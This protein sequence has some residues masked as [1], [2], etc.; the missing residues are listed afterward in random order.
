M[1]RIVFSYLL[2]LLSVACAAQTPI[3]IQPVKELKPT[4]NLGTCGYTPVPTEKPFYDKLSEK[5]RETGSFLAAYDIHQKNAEYVSWFGI[6]RGIQRMPNSDS[7]ELLL[8]QKYFDGMTDCHIMLVSKSGSGDFAVRLDAKN[9]P[10]PALALVR[11]YG[12]VTRRENATP[13]VQAEFVRVWPWLTF[14]LTDLG[15]EDKSNPR[16]KKECQ[17]CE[18]G[19]VYKPYPSN[20]YYRLTLGDPSQYGVFYK[21]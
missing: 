11:V 3:E 20:D 15:A 10:A 14:T 8:E 6:V 18:R 21:P 9:V 2:A 16:W 19:K 4:G 13:L 12:V 7:W 1:K 17:L 5:E